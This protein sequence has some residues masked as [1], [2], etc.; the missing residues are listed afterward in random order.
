MADNK[1]QDLR[2]S[3]VEELATQTTSAI[4]PTTPSS[5]RSF[6]LLAI[7]W[8]ISVTVKGWRSLF[9]SFL[10]TFVAFFF[11]RFAWVAIE[12]LGSF[13]S[14]VDW[15]S[16]GSVAA[17]ADGP[18]MRLPPEAAHKI[19]NIMNG[20]RDAFGER[21]AIP[22][23]PARIVMSGRANEVCVVDTTY[24]KRDMCSA[25]LRPPDGPVESCHTPCSCPNAPAPAPR[26]WK[27][28]DIPL[29]QLAKAFANAMPELKDACVSEPSKCDFTKSVATWI[30][31]NEES[32]KGY[33]LT[34]PLIYL[35]DA[36]GTADNR[37]MVV[38]YPARDSS[39]IYKNSERPWYKLPLNGT[40]YAPVG[41][42]TRCALTNPYQDAGAINGLL[43][44]LVCWP[45]GPENAQPPYLL[46]IDLL[47]D[48]SGSSWPQ[49]TALSV[50][51]V[52]RHWL[53]NLVLYGIVLAAFVGV[54]GRRTRRQ[55]THLRRLWNSRGQGSQYTSETEGS[56]E[57]SV[58]AGL[59][60]AAG[61]AGMKARAAL[62]ATETWRDETTLRVD[63]EASP[64]VRGIEL[65][66][67][68][69]LQ[70]WAFEVFG[71][72]LLRHDFVRAPTLVVRVQHGGKAL[73]HFEYMDAR[74]KSSTDQLSITTQDAIQAHI[75]AG[76][77]DAYIL[78]GA[79]S[80]HG[81]DVDWSSNYSNVS[82]VHDN[83]SSLRAG[84]LQFSDG[85]KV[86]RQLYAAS[87]VQAVTRIQDLLTMLDSEREP[88]L[89]TG[90]TIERLALCQ[91]REVWDELQLRQPEKIAKL[92]TRCENRLRVAFV[93]C[94]SQDLQ[95][96]HD[97]EFT[98]IDQRVV[99]VFERR[100]QTSDK[101]FISG[102]ISK[103]A[104]D[105]EFY[106]YLFKRL[107][108]RAEPIQTATHSA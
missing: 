67:A 96:F 74:T 76:G 97:L 94:L 84:R 42:D 1:L 99:I 50:M 73:P 66:E 32:L 64:E 22:D 16:N 28:L 59:D 56:Q 7:R 34:V 41:N 68:R 47:W 60:A 18:S 55:G 81:S 63:Y 105:V 89:R 82:D 14:Y 69:K 90:D 88:L 37:G 75:L 36:S 31:L 24:G 86:A 43:R 77:Q 57:I 29:Q 20:L 51:S 70:L 79:T 54:F 11:L 17:V 25:L 93:D 61:G 23:M 9:S 49:D 101:L 45:R 38:S 100:T 15:T 52:Q 65:W 83:V 33:R 106:R 4:I 92:Y 21:V 91:S 5:T 87:E 6:D 30:Q 72:E 39:S 44:T 78:D 40:E 107:A 12:Q 85:T 27:Q 103:K 8:P 35:A 10:L 3:W 48:T 95:S 62:S 13:A 53:T 2:R 58:E 46:A 104:A 71:L 26:D 108:K 98:L 19:E 102:Y 80:S